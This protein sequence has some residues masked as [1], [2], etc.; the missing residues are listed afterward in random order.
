MTYGYT[1]PV[2]I[3]LGQT[4]PVTTFREGREGGQQ[5]DKFFF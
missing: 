2:L 3:S 4:T 1:Q 5:K